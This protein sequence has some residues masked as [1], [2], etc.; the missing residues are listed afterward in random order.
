SSSALERPLTTPRIV[1]FSAWQSPP[2]VSNPILL[3]IIDR[4][5]LHYSFSTLYNTLPPLDKT[6]KIVYTKVPRSRGVSGALYLQSAT[7]G[8]MPIR[9]L[10]SAE[11]P[12]ISGADVR[13]SRNRNLTSAPLI[14]GSS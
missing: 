1:A 8:V 14:K 3:I 2:L 7:A 6:G 10:L 13:V 11:L 12:F 4:T 9:G 5:P